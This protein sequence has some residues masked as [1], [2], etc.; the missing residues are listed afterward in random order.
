MR[1]ADA[2]GARRSP[3][4]NRAIDKSRLL[5]IRGGHFLLLPTCPYSL[6]IFMSKADF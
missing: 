1:A 2:D 5:K 6:V 3:N 4:D